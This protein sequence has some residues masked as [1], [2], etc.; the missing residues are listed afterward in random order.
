MTIS[1]ENRRETDIDLITNELSNGPKSFTHI[2]RAT[3]LPRK[4]LSLRLKELCEQGKLVR[5]DGGYSLNGEHVKP[6]K[7]GRFVKFSNMSPMKR[8][9]SFAILM[10]LLVGSPTAITALA[11]FFASPVH[12]PVVLGKFN[13]V[14]SVSQVSDLY[15]W[16]VALTFNQNELKVLNVTSGGFVGGDFPTF[17][18]NIHS[19]EGLVLIYGS[20]LGRVGGK[21]GDGS[22]AIVLFG[23]LVEDYELPMIVYD[24]ASFKTVLLDSQGHTIDLSENGSPHMILSVEQL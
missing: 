16:Q 23:Y 24:G 2:L 20:L 3:E 18:Y 15:A 12:E 14:V 6:A 17:G 4:T 5:K 22:L 7:S 21:S 8:M 19:E 11:A 13:A 9:V 10:M 1:L